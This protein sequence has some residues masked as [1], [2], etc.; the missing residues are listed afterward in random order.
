MRGLDHINIDTDKPEATI[1]FY[2]DVLGLENRP[3]DRPGDPSTGAWLFSGDK[4]LVHLNFGTEDKQGPTGAF[5][6]AAFQ[7]TDFAGTCNQ[8]DRLGIEYRVAQ[9]PERSF[10]QIFLH[11]PN[12]V[13]LE[14]NIDNT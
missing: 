1:E 7:C 8:L 11:D 13:F 14:L 6:H 9:R 12:G 5:N 2:T 4:A 3:A 10:S